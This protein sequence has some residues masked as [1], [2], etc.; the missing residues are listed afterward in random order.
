[1]KKILI[2]L[3]ALVVTSA[4]AQQY[5]VS[6]CKTNKVA[7]IN[8]DGDI[9]WQ[10]PVK[11]ADSNDSEVTREGNIL[12]AYKFGAKLINRNH[13]VIWDFPVTFPNEDLNTA[14]QLDN[15]N[16][17]IAYCGHPA[18][19]IELDASGKILSD[20]TYDTGVAKVHNQF[21][22]MCKSSRNTYLLPIM[23]K[24]IVV[25]LSESGEVLRKVKIE[26][27]IFSVE[28][29][30]N[31]NWLVAGGGGHYITEMNPDS[32]EIIN[33]IGQ[34]DLPFCKLLYVTY[35]QR[36]KNG[37]TLFT[38]W[39]GHDKG[40]SEPSIVEYDKRGRLVWKFE[41]TDEIPE[42]SCIQVIDKKLHF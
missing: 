29:L 18:H 12:Y 1:M 36:L 8:R 6:G 3:M 41:S 28:E 31:G 17:L 11:G 35:T 9:L 15:G 33:R 16:Y 37:N 22:Q 25:E 19:I 5:L 40:E 34:S 26:P 14:T 13:E 24:G 10:S 20:I 23:P 42:V 2:A 38:N 7:V 4:N 27:G 21:R 39:G 32:G 30:K